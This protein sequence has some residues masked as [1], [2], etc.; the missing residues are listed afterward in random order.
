MRAGRG[1]GPFFGIFVIIL[2]GFSLAH[3]L[4][5]RSQLEGFQSVS[6][7]SIT[8]LRSLLGDFDLVELE[9]A[10]PVMGPLLFLLFVVLACFVVLNM[11]IAVI[12]DAY[13]ACQ[14]E[15]GENDGDVNILR[16]MWEYIVELLGPLPCIGP[17]I[18][19]LKEAADKLEAK[20]NEMVM[21]DGDGDEAGNQNGDE[22]DSRT[23]SSIEVGR[24][25][26]IEEQIL[27]Q[28][29]QLK[30]QL[31]NIDQRLNAH[32]MPI[33]SSVADA[34]N[35]K[36]MPPNTPKPKLKPEHGVATSTTDVV[37]TPETAT[38][39]ATNIRAPK[40]HEPDPSFTSHLD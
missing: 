15:M 37:A 34:A 2:F 28:I 38:V 17:W 7:S 12:S 26:G 30:N 29:S 22:S 36:G 5:F 10:A 6:M 19:R 4:M 9:R 24:I 25:G 20:L 18:K 16:E 35:P 21:G 14:E 32:E 23:G 1:I 13:I 33:V 31:Q 27:E 39:P 8:L 3:T 40:Y 11:L